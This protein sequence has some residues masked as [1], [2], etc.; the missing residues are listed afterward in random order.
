M[1]HKPLFRLVLSALFAALI[2]AGSYLAI[3]FVPVPL[4]LANFF[5]LLAGLLLGPVHGGLAVLIYLVLG[6]LGLP[7]FSGGSGGFG[8]FASPT[9]GFLVGYL[10]SAVTAGLAA[11]GFRRGGT[12]P[13]LLR[14]ALAGFLGLVVLYTVGLPWFQAVVSA[15]VPTLWAAFLF[16]SPYLLGDAV[17]VAAA[18]ALSRSLLPLLK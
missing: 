4:V 9:G 6:S 10:L 7:V 18:V 17:K 12:A 11:H 1:T 14:L 8:Q 2:V 13:G 16:M 5:A 3:P 15:K